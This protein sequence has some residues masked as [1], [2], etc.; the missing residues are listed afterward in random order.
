MRTTMGCH[1]GG[2]AVRRMLLVG[3][4]GFHHEHAAEAQELGA[5][6]TTGACRIAEDYLSGRYLT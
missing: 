1:C 4:V 2:P 3:W 6:Y 5:A